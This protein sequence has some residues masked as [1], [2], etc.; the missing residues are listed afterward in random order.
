MKLVQRKRVEAK[1]FQAAFASPPDVVG[2]GVA[3]PVV[4][5][6]PD[7]P[8]LGGDDQARRVGVERA[9]DQALADARTVAVGGVDEIDAELDRLTQDM[10]RRLRVGGQAPDL[11][12]GQAHRA[13]AY[14]VYLEVAADPEGPGGASADPCAAA[15]DRPA[16][17]A[18]VAGAM[19]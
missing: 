11:G 18:T 2:P 8:G 12:A 14:P 3:R 4:G 17:L 9:G 6:R 1:P 19:L 5:R 15:H 13:E 10:N 16:P 7:V